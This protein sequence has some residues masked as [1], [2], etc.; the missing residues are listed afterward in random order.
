MQIISTTALC[1]YKVPATKKNF[2][3][4]PGEPQK[5]FSN[6]FQDY[7]QNLRTFKDFP[8]YQKKNPELFQDVA[9]LVY[10]M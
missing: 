9:T 6:I 7:E 10:C 3:F 8:G 5:N 1:N 4:C 2:T